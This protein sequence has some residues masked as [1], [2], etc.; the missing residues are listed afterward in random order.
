M[1]RPEPELRFVV[2][3]TG[4]VLALLGLITVLTMS[5]AP[6]IRW[7]AAVLWLAFCS[8]ELVRLGRAYRNYE[9]I[10]L[11]AD[12]RVE[13]R[14]TDRVWYAAELMDGSTVL[15]RLAWLRIRVEDGPNFGELLRG[16]CRGKDSWRRLQVV[17]RHLGSAA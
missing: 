6:A 17:W 5:I 7:S 1:L 3:A 16:D 4:C 8:R 13:I 12:G 9:A 15:E 10:R 11:Y 14:A 2:I